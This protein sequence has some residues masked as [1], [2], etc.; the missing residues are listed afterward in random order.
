LVEH[1]GGEL[2]RLGGVARHRLDEGVDLARRVIERSASRLIS[3]AT[4][5]SRG[6]RRPPAPTSMRRSGEEV[7]LGRRSR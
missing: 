4:T 5:A 3:S 1:L 2:D 6:R 7:G